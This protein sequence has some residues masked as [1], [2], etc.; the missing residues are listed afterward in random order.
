MAG[1]EIHQLALDAADVAQAEHRAP[2]DRAAFR[3][4]RTAGV[5]GERHDEAAAVAAQRVDRVLHA[6]RRRWLQPG[7]E[8]EHALRQRAR[9]DDAG[10]AEDFRLVAARRPGHQHLRLRQQQRLEPVDFGVQRHGLRRARRFRCVAAAL[11]VRSSTMVASTA[12]QSRPKVS[13][14]VAMCWRL[15]AR[16][17]G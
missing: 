10:V 14:S 1:G 3:L 15:T 8:G 11:R 16:R 4:E 12:K 9:D 5:G 17:R 6:L 13:V 7:A 2:G